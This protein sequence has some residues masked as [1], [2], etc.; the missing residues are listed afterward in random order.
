MYIVHILI[1]IFESFLNIW[2]LSNQIKVCTVSISLWSG[3][4]LS[5]FCFSDHL[6][7]CVGGGCSVVSNSLQ[8]MDDSPPGSSVHGISQARTL[9]WVTISS[10]RGSSLPRDQTPASCIGQKI[11]YHRAT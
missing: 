8:P 11:L 4:L 7:I 2:L 9:E 10:S 1:L 6:R 5:W 3:S